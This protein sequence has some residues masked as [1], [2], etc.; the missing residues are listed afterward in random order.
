MTNNEFYEAIYKPY[1]ENNMATSTCY[2]RFGIIKKRLLE[3]YGEDNI[4]DISSHTIEAIYDDMENQQYAQ[5]TIFGTYAALYSY[6]RL[7]ADSG[8]ILSNPVEFART[9]SADIINRR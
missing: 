4:C 9:I 3:E 8:K 6:F 2:T 5:N 7:A 1:Q